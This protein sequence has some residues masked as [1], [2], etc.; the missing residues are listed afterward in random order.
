[1]NNVKLLF[2]FLYFHSKKLKLEISLKI[3]KQEHSFVVQPLSTPKYEETVCRY[4]DFGRLV[5]LNIFI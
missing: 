3:R 4:V 1:M 2:D 5:I